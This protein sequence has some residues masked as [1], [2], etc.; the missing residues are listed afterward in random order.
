MKYLEYIVE[1]IKI[2]AQS[3]LGI[4]AL[5]IVFMSIVAIVLFHNA[6]GKIRIIGFLVL[7]MGVLSFTYA[8]IQT[9]EDAPIGGPSIEVN[10]RN[11]NNDIHEQNGENEIKFAVE[12]AI[13]STITKPIIVGVNQKNRTQVKQ[14][15]YIYLGTFK[16]DQW[17][18]ARFFDSRNQLKE[19]DE[20][21]LSTDR[22][23]YT[24]APYRKYVFSFKYTF[25]NKRIGYLKSG[26][27]AIITKPIKV[28]G[29]NRVWAYV[30][31]VI[32]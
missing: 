27:K 31:G 16:N 15:G 7:I 18:N 9:T 28:V 23:L 2:A 10:N 21:S 17:E 20:V 32:I 8:S 11:T 19:G 14:S 30:E 24:C 4:I 3:Q 1:A 29:F 26:S 22:N 5:V 13:K 12:P 6:S 25:C